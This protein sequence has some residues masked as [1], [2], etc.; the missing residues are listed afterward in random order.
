MFIEIKNNPKHVIIQKFS[1]ASKWVDVAE[2]HDRNGMDHYY[3][4]DL[5]YTFNR[6]HGYPDV[7]AIVRSQKNPEK[8]RQVLSITGL[9]FYNYIKSSE[10]YYCPYIVSVCGDDKT[11]KLYSLVENP[12]FL[13]KEDFANLLI[14]NKG[15]NKANMR[16]IVKEDGCLNT[17]DITFNNGV[18]VTM[19]ILATRL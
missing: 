3:L 16:D 7:R 10:K 5:L 19:S 9:T 12:H 2:V 8:F 1:K 15:I 4:A 14:D 11:P 13:G 18:K 6:L 17:Y